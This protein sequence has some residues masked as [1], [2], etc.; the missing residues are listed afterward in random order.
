[1]FQNS[2]GQQIG[3]VTLVSNASQDVTASITVPINAQIGDTVTLDFLVSTPPP[4]NKTGHAQMANL[5]VASTSG[6]PVVHSVKFTNVVLPVG[7]TSNA[8]PNQIF[9]YGFSVRYSATQPPNTENFTFTA[10]LIATGNWF[11]DFAGA[12]V[13]KSTSLSGEILFTTPVALTSGATDTTVT[14]R[15]R[16]PG[17]R[18]TQDQVA[19][20]YISIDSTDLPD[21]A[22]AHP[23]GGPFTIVLKHT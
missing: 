16:A 12:P 15:V 8:N 11:V 9:T 10:G 20:L 14:V 6:N 21:Q 18:T 17:T 13:T 4:N 5:S 7:D 23:A 3:S 1:V 22:S 19:T 2:S